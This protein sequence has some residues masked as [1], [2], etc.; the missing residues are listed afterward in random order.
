MTDPPGKFSIGGLKLSPELIQ[1]RL[2]P[3]AGV[4]ITE[5][6]QRLAEK[7]VNL[8][9]LTVETVDGRLTG[10]GYLSA[11]DGP[12][13]E[14]ALR[15]IGKICQ[16]LSPLGALTVFPL[17]ARVDLIGRLLGALGRADLP[18]YG[19]A[20]SLSSLTIITDYQRLDEAASAVCRVVGLPE[21]HAPLRPEFRVKQL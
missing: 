14:R 18:V 15:P 2:L 1:L 17:R 13:A 19:I 8:F 10:L 5:M 3:Q 7:Q 12:A 16:I 21:N 6:L 11:E 20:S 4:T 9:G